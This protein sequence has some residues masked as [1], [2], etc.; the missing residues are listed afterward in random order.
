MR[1]ESPRQRIA[2]G[3]GGHQEVR[4]AELLPDVPDGD[5]GA[6]AARDVEDGPDRGPGDPERE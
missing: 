1:P 6:D 3:G 5:L 2:D 4:V